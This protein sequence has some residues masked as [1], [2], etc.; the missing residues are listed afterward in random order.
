MCICIFIIWKMR[1]YGIYPCSAEI[2]F[3]K[4][5]SVQEFALMNVL[6]QF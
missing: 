2:D 6:H 3:S 1:M 4:M 5:Y